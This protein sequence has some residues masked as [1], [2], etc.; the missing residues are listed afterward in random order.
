M[1]APK[2][3]K[4]G[5]EMTGGA[6]HGPWPVQW[7]C[8]PCGVFVPQQQGEPPNVDSDAATLPM[9][10]P[11]ETQTI[12]RNSVRML[13][14]KHAEGYTLAV[15]VFVRPDDRGEDVDVKWPG[16]VPPRLVAALLTALGSSIGG[17]DGGA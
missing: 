14:E 12:Y 1:S 2:C 13:A 10:S 15:A 4:C 7:E 16:C 6:P 8:R 9:L 17:K 3:P 11:A 5:R